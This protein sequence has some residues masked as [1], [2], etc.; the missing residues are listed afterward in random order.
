MMNQA[1]HAVGVEGYG[2]AERA[3][4]KAVSYARERK[5]GKTLLG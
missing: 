3:Y 2:I 5:Q 1:R 4:Q